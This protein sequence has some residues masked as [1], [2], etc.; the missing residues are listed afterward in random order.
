MK[1]LDTNLLSETAEG[2]ALVAQECR[3]CGKIAYPRKRV[4]PECFGED[5]VDRPLSRSGTLHTYATTYLGVPRI[6]LPYVIGFVD[7]PEKIRLFGL[8]IA[9]SDASLAVGQRMDIVVSKL[10]QDETGEDVFGYKF[11][12]AAGGG[13]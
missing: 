7:V 11:R 3:A 5:L 1:I 13:R 8:I 4:C 12:P 9:D 2:W 6:G 10:F